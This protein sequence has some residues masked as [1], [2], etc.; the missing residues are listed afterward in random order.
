MP[1]AKT[2]T[3]P[4]SY[5]AIFAATLLA[6]LPALR[7]SLLWDDDHHVTPPALQSLH[8]L[9]RIWFDPSATQQYY[10][11][12]HT[13]FWL[14]HRLWGDSV[15]GYH[16]VNLLLHATAACL[17]VAIA[18]RLDL[19]GALLAGFLFA[20]HP[21]C[22]EA[23]A[24]IS[25]QKS[26][27]SAVFYLAAALA[28]LD[29]DRTRRRALYFF[30]TVLFVCALSS[31]TVTATLPAAALVVLWWK[32]G[33][34]NSHRD[35]LPLA[36]WFALAIPAGLATAWIERTAIGA[37]GPDFA[38][39]FA[40]HI[41]LA[42]RALCFYAVKLVWPSHLIF[43]YPRWTLDPADGRQWLF[44]AAVLALGIALAFLARRKRGP[45]AASLF[46]AGTLFPVL[47]F[48]NVYPFVFSWAAD[49]FQYLATLGILLPAAY[50]LSFLPYRAGWLVPPLLTVLTWQQAAI[51]RN[52]ETLYRATLDRNSGSWMAHT[53]L[54]S[55]LET[56][57]TRLA[58]AI[59]HCRSALAL[60]PNYAEAHNNL[61]AALAQIPGRIPDAIAEFQSAIRLRPAFAEAHFNLANAWL[62]AEPLDAIAEYRTAIRLKPD[63]L[64]AR[65]NLGTVLSR[66]PERRP[67]AIGE[68]EAALRLNPDAAE[69]HNNLAGALAR[70][71]GRTEEA[72]AQYRE[73]L[74]IDPHYAKAHNNLGIVLS[75]IPGSL[76]DAIAEY[77]AALRANPDYADAH[78][79]LGVAWAHAGRG[80]EAIGEFETALRLNP[81]FSQARDNLAILRARANSQR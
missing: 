43:T 8:G 11:L 60:R 17:V 67:E 20:L 76:P 56:Q 55:L 80:G 53:N 9:W 52:G 81:A 66:I 31:K 35:I 59:D 51:Y 19:R 79:N 21:V 3:H 40:Q 44:P 48:F 71:H 28:Y 39:S 24:W 4:F 70:S 68:Y 1:S 36:P 49:H 14:E 73:A 41:L 37:Q 26:T 38:L 42:S 33:R 57:P 58:E 27:L 2:R 64:Q 34:L 10:P 30:A 63:Y 7:G 75:Q 6:Y 22:V 12:L 78:Y 72:I 23:V 15:L 77:Q 47:G 74:R 69:V 46:F 16:L 32:R 54:C 65:L 45:M 62:A 50:G 5:A 25:E 18:R 29:F 13:A 61:G